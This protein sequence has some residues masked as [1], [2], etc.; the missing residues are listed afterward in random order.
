M[1]VVE[2]TKL[3]ALQRTLRHLEMLVFVFENG[4]KN[5]ANVNPVVKIFVIVKTNIRKPCNFYVLDDL[6]HT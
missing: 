4:K 1:V 2:I 3:E 6:V 5:N